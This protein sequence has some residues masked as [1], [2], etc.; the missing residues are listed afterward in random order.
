MQGLGTSGLGPARL[1]QCMF[2]DLAGLVHLQGL[3]KN[4]LLLIFHLFQKQGRVSSVIN[5]VEAF[6]FFCKAAGIVI[7]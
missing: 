4:Y 2:L 5:T 3:E 7:K 6:T 1:E